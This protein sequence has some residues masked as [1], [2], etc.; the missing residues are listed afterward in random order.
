[1]IIFVVAIFLLTRNPP[2][3][4][5]GKRWILAFITAIYCA[6]VWAYSRHDRSFSSLA[7][8]ILRL[9]D[10][11]LIYFLFSSYLN[12]RARVALV[13]RVVWLSLLGVNVISLGV[14]RLGYEVGMTGGVERYSGLYNDAGGPAFN[15]VF[16]IVFAVFSH[17]LAHHQRKS[18]WFLFAVAISVITGSLLLWMSLA[19]S[20]FAMLGV[21]V[22]LWWGIHKKMYYLVIPAIPAVAFFMY[23]GSEDVRI[24][25]S[26][27]VRVV[28]DGDYS[29]QA[30]GSM[31]TGRVAN[32]R[33]LGRMYAGLPWQRQLFGSG[34][35]WGIH[36]QYFSYLL[37][38]GVVGF[39]CFAGL[40]TTLLLCTHA[41]YRR[42]GSPEV[43][44]GLTVLSM[45]AVLG[46]TGIPFEYTTMYWY[47]LIMV[48]TV[49]NSRQLRRIPRRRTVGIAP[50]I[51]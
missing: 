21:F 23:S 17:E 42:T 32:W 27:E 39:T 41:E 2:S 1:V 20:A 40:L 26:N 30:I 9:A 31:G 4:V 51:R 48:S 3:K 14:S 25:M 29:E 18:F 45:F 22:I 37:R 44:M 34:R 16:C 24:R 6:S 49:N 5:V 8:I 15:G 43:F 7:D 33:R 12:T 38:G 13:S 19:K 28:V 47:V 11:Y 46:L 50:H 35:D 36:N 10:S